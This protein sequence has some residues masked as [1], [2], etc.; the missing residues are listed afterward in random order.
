MGCGFQPSQTP[1][2]ARIS[3]IFGIQGT[4]LCICILSLG[5]LWGCHF[6]NLMPAMLST[7]VCCKTVGITILLLEFFT[8]TRCF[9]PQASDCGV[10]ASSLTRCEN[11]KKWTDLLCSLSIHAT[12][13]LGTCVLPPSIF[14]S[15]DASTATCQLTPPSDACNVQCSGLAH[16]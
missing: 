6:C 7:C 9:A 4:H 13:I 8:H 10:Q 14:N 15:D 12:A 11:K 5:L 3:K 2:G 16:L 1:W